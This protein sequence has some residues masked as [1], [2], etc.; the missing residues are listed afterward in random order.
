V[1]GP[2]GCAECLVARCCLT[3][4]SCAGNADCAAIE[5]CLAGGADAGSADAGDCA[6]GH[7]AG[8]WLQTGLDVCRRNQCADACGAPAATC[9]GTVRDPRSGQGAVDAL[10]C[11]ETAAC[12][13][14]DACA[15]LLYQCL[16]Q[17]GCGTTGPCYEAS[18]ALY[19]AALPAFDAMAS[20]WAGVTC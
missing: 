2:P 16:D 14:S 7:V 15:A 12:G 8:V 10:C 19:P 6:E 18:R 3:A 5:R 17:G 1:P 13:Q 4:S 20:C 11:G 9:G